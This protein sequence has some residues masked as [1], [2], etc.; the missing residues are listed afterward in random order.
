MVQARAPPAVVKLGRPIPA[1]LSRREETANREVVGTGTGAGTE[2]TLV[3]CGDLEVL[4][5]GRDAGAGGDESA[6]GLRG[7]NGMDAIRHRA[8]KPPP[9][10][11]SI[12]ANSTLHLSLPDSSLHGCTCTPK[13]LAEPFAVRFRF[14]WVHLCTAG[15]KNL[16][17]SVAC[18]NW[19]FLGLRLCTGGGK[20]LSELVL[21]DLDNI[22]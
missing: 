20:N 11:A 4:V 5:H 6:H 22:G 9:E 17:E 14:F 18:P 15:G 1:A 7:G 8:P 13:N 3:L 19:V 16:A 10:P 12:W 21:S 2:T